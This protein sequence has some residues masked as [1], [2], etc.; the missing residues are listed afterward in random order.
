ML[1]HS[2]IHFI[3]HLLTYS[4][5]QD[6]WRK[7]NDTCPMCKAEY[8]INSLVLSKTTNDVARGLLRTNADELNEWLSLTYSLTYL[9]TH[10]RAQGISIRKWRKY[11]KND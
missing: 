11:E 4:F 7:K 6:W 1:T 10:S 2:L 8:H 9:L 3:T 5:F